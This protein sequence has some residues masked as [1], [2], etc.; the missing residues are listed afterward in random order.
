MVFNEWFGELTDAQWRAYR[1]HNISPA[2]HD[3]WVDTGF[4]GD[5]IAEWVCTIAALDGSLNGWFGPRWAQRWSRHGYSATSTL[6]VVGSIIA[7]T[8]R[9]AVEVRPSDV[10]LATVARQPSLFENVV[11]PLGV[12]PC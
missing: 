1:R 2:D 12:A 6:E 8:G 3:D 4:D 10:H 5:A 9:R 7:L 11:E